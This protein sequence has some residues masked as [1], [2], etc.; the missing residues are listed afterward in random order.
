M[1]KYE[2]TVIIN[3]DVSE[4]K[5]GSFFEKIKELIINEGCLLIELD[6]WGTQKLA[7][8]IKKKFRGNYTCI[9]YCGTSKLVDEIERTFSIDDSVLKYMTVLLDKNVDI[10]KIKQEMAAAEAK[11][12]P[13][14]PTPSDDATAAK[15]TE[16]AAPEPSD[17]PESDNSTEKEEESSQTENKEEEN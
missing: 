15:T 9:S 1:R 4:E 8:E 11:D 10:D 17:A 14:V 5:R 16:T 3:P 13:V 6:T 12:E 2:T 7:Y